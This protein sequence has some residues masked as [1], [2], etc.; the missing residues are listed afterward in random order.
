MDIQGFVKRRASPAVPS[1]Q[2][3]VADTSVPRNGK[4]SQTRD[5]SQFHVGYRES[6]EY[7]KAGEK[8]GRSKPHGPM[9]PPVAPPARHVNPQQ[10][11]TFDQT[12][13][14]DMF[15]TDADGLD[16]TSTSILTEQGADYTTARRADPD[17]V[18]VHAGTT[19]FPVSEP[20]SESDDSEGGT[21]ESEDGD[22]DEDEDGE[23]END[24]GPFVGDEV[25]PEVQ[26]MHAMA[27]R[28]QEFQGMNHADSYPETSSGVPEAYVSDHSYRGESRPVGIAGMG[29]VM[30][31]S[32]QRTFEGPLVRRPRDPP[33][34]Q[35]IQ[36]SY[37]DGNDWE[38]MT[39]G[40]QYGMAAAR[41]PLA[42]NARQSKHQATRHA[43]HHRLNSNGG[44]AYDDASDRY[45]HSTIP[46]FV[47]VSGQDTGMESG[48]KHPQTRLRQTRNRVSLPRAQQKGD[49][50]PAGVRSQAKPRQQIELDYDEEVLFKEKEF[51][52]LQSE[53]YDTDP[54]RHEQEVSNE[55]SEGSLAE[56]LKAVAGVDHERQKQYFT[57]LDIDQWEDAGD[58]FQEQFAKLMKRM[59]EKRREKRGLALTFEKE[60]A[61]R[62]EQVVG[63]RKVTDEALAAMKGAGVHVL[64]TPK[65]MRRQG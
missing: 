25:R 48:S 47:G 52:E 43:Q 20:R 40:S 19:Q 31:E 38:P 14:S 64:E 60:I 34:R 55:F 63:K 10:V 26:A 50:D 23:I 9:M 35:Q 21:D 49:E 62:H 11:D 17:L 41:Q 46:K 16:N 51:T 27:S 3:S 4:A 1:D 22:E 65:K 45:R 18:T 44:R 36:E 5:A 53:K 6:R 59:K 61:Q 12:M 8:N 24:A 28:F 37:V 54:R 29:P 7:V 58:W 32:L 30:D 33:P 2:H 56:Q 39:S 13:H 15:G 57:T 42:G